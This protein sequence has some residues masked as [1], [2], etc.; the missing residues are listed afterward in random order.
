ML[1]P[2]VDPAVEQLLQRYPASLAA[3]RYFLSSPPD[4]IQRALKGFNPAKEGLPDY[5]A[6]LT[7]FV[8][9]L[10]IALG[11]GHKRPNPEFEAQVGPQVEGFLQRYPVDEGA[12]AYLLGSTVMVQARVV[13]EF[14]PSREDERDYSA[15]VL[16]FCKRC[17][18]D[19]HAISGRQGTP[20]QRAAA[21]RSAP[22]PF[23]PWSPGAVPIPS[24]LAAEFFEKYPV[25]E[26]AKKYFMAASPE[27]QLKILRDFK[28]PR[29]GDK[30]YS[31]IFVS[32]CKTCKEQQPAQDAGM[33]AQILKPAM[34]AAPYG[35][36]PLGQGATSNATM[37]QMQQA[38]AGS[39]DTS[40]IPPAFR[41]AALQAGMGG[42][43][44]GFAS[45]FGASTPQLEAKARPTITVPENVQAFRLRYPMDDNAI[46]Y[47]VNS[48][49]EVIDRVLSTFVPPRHDSDYSAPI[50]AYVRSCRNAL[51]AGGPLLAAARPPP[52]NAVGDG[53]RGFFGE[54]H[55]FHGSGDEVDDQM[56]EEAL[57]RFIEKYPIDDRAKLYLKESSVEV[58]SR[59]LRDFKAKNEGEQDYS[60]LVIA[61]TKACRNQE[62][63]VA[64]QAAMPTGPSKRMR[65]YR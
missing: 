7:A 9:R 12:S 38:M 16:T 22:S 51:G 44:Q 60:A 61:F 4:V 3:T 8:K 35:A 41:L 59:V 17:R 19:D 1:M 49:P 23:L 5:S 26:K 57:G 21:P 34:A 50:T 39:V 30:D 45:V 31:R 46:R 42:G 11:H 32:F 52:P 53:D 62:M 43:L 56:T 10:R 58:I 13:R 63:I 54:F 65:V 18:G 15:L 33:P 47:L 55:S 36:P 2:G 37:L 6:L 29:E 27:T 24:D 40:C 28:P 48:G 64:T 25:D 20:E 14:K